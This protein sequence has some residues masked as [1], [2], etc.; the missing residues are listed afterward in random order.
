MKKNSFKIL[1][2]SLLLFGCVK[3]YKRVGVPVHVD[4]NRTLIVEKQNDWDV[5]VAFRVTLINKNA[6]NISTDILLYSPP[7]FNEIE[8]I[9]RGQRYEFIRRSNGEEEELGYY[10]SESNTLFPMYY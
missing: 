9:K 2:A 8:I 6:N 10:D 4:E 1:V 7:G 3:E 5:S